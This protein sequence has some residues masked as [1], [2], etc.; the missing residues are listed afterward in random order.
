MNPFS[1]NDPDLAAL[2]TELLGQSPRLDPGA[3]QAILYQSAFQA[4][5]AAAS[6]TNRIWQACTAGL[7]LMLVATL[8]PWN[9]ADLT[10]QGIPTQLPPTQIPSQ[11]AVIPPEDLPLGTHGGQGVSA[12]AW[13]TWKPEDNKS[14]RFDQELK[15][16]ALLE[17]Q[18]K[19]HSLIQFSR[20]ESLGY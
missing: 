5:K 12:I 6:K 7:G 3:Q 18:E 11:M 10:P 17:P 9:R 2:E 19:A 20:L 8:F 13:E 1:L 4:G 16:F 15:K 14:E